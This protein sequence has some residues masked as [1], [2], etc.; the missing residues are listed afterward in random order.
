MKERGA[1][2]ATL[3]AAVGF[4]MSTHFPSP[5]NIPPSGTVSAA[6]NFEGDDVHAL[7]VEEERQAAA[8]AL[9]G[10]SQKH[11]FGSCDEEDDAEDAF[12]DSF[13]SMSDLMEA[14]IGSSGRTDDLAAAGEQH[15]AHKTVNANRPVAAQNSGASAVNTNKTAVRKPNESSLWDVTVTPIHCRQPSRASPANS[16]D[17]APSGSGSVIRT[18]VEPVVA[19]ATAECEHRPR[20][21]RSSARCPS[22]HSAAAST[23]STVVMQQM[24]ELIEQQQKQME[25][26]QKQNEAMLAQQQKL[27]EQY[28]KHK[29]VMLTLFTKAAS[30]SSNDVASAVA[31]GRPN[32]GSAVE[33]N[34]PKTGTSASKVPDRNDPSPTKSAA[35]EVAAPAPAV[36]AAAV[37]PKPSPSNTMRLKE[38]AE[39][40]IKQLSRPDQGQSALF[41]SHTV[42][43]VLESVSI[44]A[45]ADERHSAQ[46]TLKDDRPADKRSCEVLVSGYRP[47]DPGGHSDLNNVWSRLDEAMASCA[48]SIGKLHESTEANVRLFAQSVS[49]NRTVDVQKRENGKQVNANDEPEWKELL[50]HSSV[51]H[52]RQNAMST[53]RPINDVMQCTPRQASQHVIR[54]DESMRQVSK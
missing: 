7:S 9:S 38:H 4:A 20:S 5:E 37:T 14:I 10:L 19:A 12:E 35:V 50:A 47:F 23:E 28:Q 25:Q 40:E 49:G 26:Y 33:T 18:A 54:D 8:A 32:V 51:Q 27:E 6:R 21:S 17:T 36:H 52:S 29:E 16:F 44:A 15:A 41:K 22:E 31:S 30:V 24:L 13:G 3:V 46:M 34:V 43:S 1:N 48:A 2:F 53:A 45:S 39:K 11:Q 42:E